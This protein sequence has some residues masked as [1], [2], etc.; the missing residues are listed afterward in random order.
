MKLYLIPI[1]L[2]E[3]ALDSLSPM[4]KQ[5]VL[6]TQYYLVENVRTA[7]RFISSLKIGVDISQLTFFEV[8]K[9][10][11]LQKLTEYFKQIPS[12][13]NVG[14]MSEAG[15][16]AVADPG[17]LAVS[18]AHKH[19]IQVVPLVG[20]SSILLAL[21]ASGLN[22]QS[23]A[24]QGYLPID[25][26]ER[27]KAIKNLEK[28]SKQKKQTQIFI[29]TPYRNNHVLEQLANDLQEETSLCIAANLT[30]ENE[31]VISKKAKEWKSDL[32]KKQLPDL[33]K[34]P[35]IFILLA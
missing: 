27:S 33:H 28:D 11:N 2:S 26:S 34:Q 8:N 31:L 9:D 29:E 15:C 17:S 35:T 32:A 10:T 1:P 3:N 22:G 16:P 30:G 4:V 12:E 20:P 19:R 24:F 21:M 14:V 18:Y 25:R 7:R 5:T 13:A 23:F 6:V